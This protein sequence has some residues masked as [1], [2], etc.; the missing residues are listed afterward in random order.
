MKEI[1]LNDFIAFYKKKIDR[2]FPCIST[3]IHIQKFRKAK[4]FN[5]IVFILKFHF[6][7]KVA[8]DVA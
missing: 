3:I 5:F 4:T 7:T 8:L 2:Q 1:D 6:D